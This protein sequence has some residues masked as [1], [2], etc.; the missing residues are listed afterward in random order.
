MSTVITIGQLA[1]AVGVRIQTVRYYERR[2]LL[3]PTARKPSGFRLYTHRE[4]RR[5]HFI[6]NAQALGFTLHEITELLNLRVNSRARCRDVK[7]TA[8]AK[9]DQVNRKT[10]DLGSLASALRGL[11]RACRA[12]QPTERCPILKTI[13]QSRRHAS[14]VR[15]RG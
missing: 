10:R 8:Q 15:Q 4:I 13:E 12:G 9:L 6:K 14:N 3:L 5:L 11:I 7:R 2:H 1:K